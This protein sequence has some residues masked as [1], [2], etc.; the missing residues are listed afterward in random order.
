M[1]IAFDADA[2]LIPPPHIPN[3]IFLKV[4]KFYAVDETCIV[5]RIKIL[6]YCPCSF[7][8]MREANCTLWN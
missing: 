5:R 8:A 4:N 6:K 7:E 1:L 2:P 3:L